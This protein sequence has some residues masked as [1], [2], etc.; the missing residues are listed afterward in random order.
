MYL[1]LFSGLCNIFVYIQATCSLLNVGGRALAGWPKPRVRC[2]PPECVFITP[3]NKKHVDSMCSALFNYPPG[4]QMEPGGMLNPFIMTMLASLL[5][6][7]RD[8]KT[9]YTHLHKSGVHPVVD[10]IIAAG[11]LCGFNE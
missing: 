5:Q 7:M 4:L 10:R 9:R 1:I 11:A 3:E 8:M 6:S 2:Y